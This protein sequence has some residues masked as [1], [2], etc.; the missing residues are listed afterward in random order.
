MRVLDEE[1]NPAIGEVLRRMRSLEEQDDRARFRDTLR[2]CGRIVGYEIAK[3]LPTK[4]HACTTPLGRRDEPVFAEQPVLVTIMRA[5]LPMWEGMLE[6]FE[7]AD[8]VIVGAARR[9]GIIATG[10]RP[11]LPIDLGYAAWANVHGRTLVYVDPMIATG[12]TLR[13]LHELLVAKAGTPKRVIVAGAI[14]YRATARELE[15]PPLSAEVVV[16]SADEGLDERGY[17]VPG[18]GDAGDLAFGPKW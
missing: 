7:G 10:E 15:K 12:S 9:E 2:R 3:T 13:A 17:I 8:N 16:A 18:L 11:C 1:N 4:A 5:S 6:I 14:A